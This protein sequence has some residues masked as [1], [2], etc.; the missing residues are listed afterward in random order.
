LKGKKKIQ[1]L[2]KYKKDYIWHALKASMLEKLFISWLM[3]HIGNC[4]NKIE[5]EED[6]CKGI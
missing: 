4:I 1:V 2:I 5:K 6:S 3:E